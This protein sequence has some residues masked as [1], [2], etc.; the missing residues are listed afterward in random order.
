MATG[1]NGRV[2][3]ACAAEGGD[4]PGLARVQE[5]TGEPRYAADVVCL[6]HTAM[7]GVPT[8]EEAY[9]WKWFWIATLVVAILLLA[10]PVR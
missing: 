2:R 3:R 1:R 8:N 10:T 7:A 5:K 4:D 9:M 6:L